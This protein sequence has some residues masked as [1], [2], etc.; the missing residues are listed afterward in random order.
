MLPDDTVFDPRV[1]TYGYWAKKGL[2]VR[3]STRAAENKCARRR[4]FQRPT[5]QAGTDGQGRLAVTTR[6]TE[7][8]VGGNRG[9]QQQQLQIRGMA[10]ALFI[11]LLLLSLQLVAAVALC[12]TA[13]VAAAAGAAALAAAVAEFVAAAVAVA[14]AAAVAVALRRTRAKSVALLTH[15]ARRAFPPPPGR[16]RIAWGAPGLS[17]VR[18]TCCHCRTP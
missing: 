16:L 13:L 18:P 15:E 10:W 17:A 11:L 3:L 2:I 1:G 7:A 12:C 6:I 5:C 8:L 9:V 4:R 14:T